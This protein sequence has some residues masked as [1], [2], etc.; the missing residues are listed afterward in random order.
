MPLNPAWFDLEQAITNCFTIGDDLALLVEH[1]LSAEELD[2][3][4]LA[5]ALIGL[6]ELNEL[7]C[8][9]AFDEYEHMLEL[10]SDK[11]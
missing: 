2:R 7:R 11:K 1:V 3:D 9:K 4:K 5:N 10:H 8:Q 6:K